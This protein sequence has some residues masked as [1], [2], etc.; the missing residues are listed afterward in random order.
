M[1]RL[2]ETLFHPHEI[3]ESFKLLPCDAITITDDKFSSPLR[4]RLETW[5]GEDAVMN[6]FMTRGNDFVMQM[7]GGRVRDNSVLIGMHFPL[8]RLFPLN[9]QTFSCPPPRF[10]EVKSIKLQFSFWLFGKKK[11]RKT[12]FRDANLIR[13]EA[14]DDVTWSRKCY[15]LAFRFLPRSNNT[16]EFRDGTSHRLALL[17]TAQ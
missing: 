6:E 16:H 7:H 15:Q 14:L 10:S 3:P 8:L 4:Q 2:D 12:S 17:I 1:S 13:D 5:E 11:Q 9:L